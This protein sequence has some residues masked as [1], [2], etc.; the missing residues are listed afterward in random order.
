MGLFLYL[1]Q[2]KENNI[3]WYAVDPN[4]GDLTMRG[5]ITTPGEPGVQGTSPD[6]KTLYVAMRSTGA[7][8]S[9]RIEPLSGQL[10]LLHVLD[11]GRADPC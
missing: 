9:F 6:R 5:N 3:T 8:C 4:T 11:T 2:L 10:D 7:L 1:S